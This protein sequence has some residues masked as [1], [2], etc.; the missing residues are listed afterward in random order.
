MI[1][2]K[3][4]LAGI[5]INHPTK[6]KVF[7]LVEGKA[8]ISTILELIDFLKDCLT[9]PLKVPPKYISQSTRALL[10]KEKSYED[11]LIER[12]LKGDIKTGL[13]GEIVKYDIKNNRFEV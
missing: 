3:K 1:Q 13:L 6:P 9:F 8:N 11:D 10:S 7:R 2:I 12:M 5:D 4:N